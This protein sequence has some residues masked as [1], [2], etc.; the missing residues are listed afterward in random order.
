LFDI[1]GGTDFDSCDEFID[2][3]ILASV[4]RIKGNAGGIGAGIFILNN[5]Q[6]WQAFQVH[7]GMPKIY[8]DKWSTLII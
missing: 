1:G 7:S 4:Y 8:G 6:F 5:V 3:F 2:V